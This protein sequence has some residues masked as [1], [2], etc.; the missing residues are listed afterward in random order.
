MLHRLCSSL[1][2]PYNIIHISISL[3]PYYIILALTFTLNIKFSV[4]T[5]Y[6]SE[7]CSTDSCNNGYFMDPD[8]PLKCHVC[9]EALDHTGRERPDW[10]ADNDEGCYDM[11]QSYL[12]DCPVGVTHCMT[13]L[14]VDWY[15]GGE[16]MLRFK[17]SCGLP[18]ESPSNL[19]C[20]E[21][22][23]PPIAYKGKLKILLQSAFISWLLS[24]VVGNFKMEIVAI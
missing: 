6:I 12:E 20:K 19:Q 13:S 14:N 11:S 22:F 5:S 9:Q 1:L 24:N 15:I 10:I 3:V 2:V 18:D 7:H 4:E 21:G 17:R 23:V 8:V 16:Q